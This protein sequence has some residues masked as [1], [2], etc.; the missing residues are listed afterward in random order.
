LQLTSL[1]FQKNIVLVVMALIFLS[2]SALASGYSSSRE[3]AVV[4]QLAD[5]DTL[6]QSG[7]WEQGL[8]LSRRLL[9]EYGDHPLYGWQLEGRMGLALLRGRDFSGSIPHLESAIRSKPDEPIFHR[10][11]AF[12]LVTIGHKGRALS[13]YT[14]AVS[15]DPGN[16]NC[17]LELGQLLLDFKNYRQAEVHLEMARQLCD[18]CPESIRALGHMHLAAGK[19]DLAV[20]LFQ[21]LLAAESTVAAR[22]DLVQALQESGENGLL[23]ELLGGWPSDQLQVDELELLIKA[24]REVGQWFYAQSFLSNRL[25]PSSGSLPSG[26]FDRHQFWAE[27]AYSL[28]LAQKWSEAVNGFGLALELDPGNGVYMNNRDVALQQLQKQERN[29]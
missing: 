23:V 14:Q 22:R 18:N 10:N 15:L 4:Q 11:L 16:A 19:P 8:S 29:K 17:Q 20:P 2:A 1:G 26:I 25:G 24:E 9:L 27:V 13:E 21:D 3:K 7:D 28:L 5:I 12:A 6:L